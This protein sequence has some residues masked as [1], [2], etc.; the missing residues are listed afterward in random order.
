MRAH[1]ITYGC[2]MNEYD[3][4]TI[5]SELVAGGHDLVA[6]PQDAELIL[7]NTCAVRGKPVEKV[8]SV[9]G[10]LRKERAAGRDLAIGLM[11]CLAQLE[12]G[13]AIATKFGVDLLIGPG[14]VT[15]IVPAIEDLERRRAASGRSGSRVDRL[16]FRDDLVDHLT[17]PPPAGTLTGYL[18]IMRGCDHHCTYCIVPQT[19]GPEVSRP[20]AAILAEAE[21]MRAQGVEEV[22]LLGQNVNSYGRDDPRVPSFAELL[23]AVAAVGFPRV[24]FT[25]SH[26][27]N[28]TSDV[29]D[30]IASSPNVCDYVHLPV[31]SGS[32]RVL[33]RMAREYR[34]ERYLEI[35][36]ELRAKV[37][38]VVLST[39][40]IVGFPGETEEDFEQTLAL[41][42]EVG[43]EQ[44]FMFA[45][46][47]R[48]GTPAHARFDDLPRAVK[49]E[50]LGRLIEKQ[51]HWS[52]VGNRRF[53]G[54]TVRVLVKE[55][56]RDGAHVVGHS[57]QHHTVLVPADQV[58][59]MGLHD[60][61]VDHAT[62]HALYGTVLGAHAPGLALPLAS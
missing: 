4:L 39:D 46:S 38:D 31:Q 23:Q 14:A 29:I 24:K 15:E 34:R 8:V 56:G 51:K 61:R 26:P 62:P 18:T 40:L 35:V 41:Y 30:A 42:D 27:M 55:L 44:A 3:T 36:R 16:A 52:L 9:L 19:R 25:T 37:P 7:L 21:A 12:E 11:G 49:T 6:T 59:R 22:V 57:D 54:R 20:L 53:E 32:D 5:Q 28:F 13:R 60:V 45:Y 50:R 48:P 2:Q 10:D 17:P 1:V 43:F 58:G 47:A 33:Q